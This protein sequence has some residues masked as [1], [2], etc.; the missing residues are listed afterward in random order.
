MIKTIFFY[1]GVVLSIILTLFGFI[2]L[3]CI[4]WKNKLDERTQYIHKMTSKWARFIMKL[5]GSK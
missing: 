4:S 3:K 1:I 5:S 2:K